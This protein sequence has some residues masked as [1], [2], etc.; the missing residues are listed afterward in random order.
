MDNGTRA[1]PTRDQNSWCHHGNHSQLAGY[2]C[3]RICLSIYSCKSLQECDAVLNH[4]EFN[5]TQIYLYPYGTS[6]FIFLC[7]VIWLYLYI[8]LPETKGRSVESITMELRER[9]GDKKVDL[10]KVIISRLMHE[11]RVLSLSNMC[12]H[13][14]A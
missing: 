5:H 10:R 3:S 6:I 7:A 12:V 11:L 8:Y 2:F 9:V 4:V 13:T 1:I 14:F